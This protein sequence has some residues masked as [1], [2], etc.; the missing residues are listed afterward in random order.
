MYNLSFKDSNGKFPGVLITWFRKHL[1]IGC[2]SHPE[3]CPKLMKG[4]KTG[5]VSVRISKHL[6]FSMPAY[7][8][9]TS[10]CCGLWMVCV[11][12]PCLSYAAWPLLALVQEL[13]RWVC[14]CEWER[15]GR[16]RCVFPIRIYGINFFVYLFCLF[17][18]SFYNVKNGAYFCKWFDISIFVFLI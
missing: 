6:C 3:Q 2:L 10:L 8:C 14:V 18:F 9:M 16:K 13:E 7:W 12:S 4:V 15:K 1:E 17:Y 11:S 5:Q